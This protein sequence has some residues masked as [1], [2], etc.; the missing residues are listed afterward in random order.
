MSCLRKDGRGHIFDS[1][2]KDYG[3]YTPELIQDMIT[4]Y[5]THQPTIQLYPDVAAILEKLRRNKIKIGI[6]TDGLSAVQKNK[7]S[8]LALKKYSDFIIYTDDFGQAFEKPHLVSFSHAQKIL[9]FKAENILYIGNAPKKDIAGANSAGMVPVHICRNVSP[10]DFSCS[11]IIHITSLNE[12]FT[13][14]RIIFYG[15]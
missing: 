6:I 12:L 13:N 15:D 10:C 14:N 3:I 5:R 7:V 9:G 11:A 4:I 8:A 2:A 1:V